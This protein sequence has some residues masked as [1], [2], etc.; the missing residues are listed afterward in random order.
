M[1][2]LKFGFLLGVLLRV[3]LVLAAQGPT[4][5]WPGTG[6]SVS[7]G[8][9]TYAVDS[10]GLA[11]N[12]SATNVTGLS[13]ISGAGEY[14]ATG[15]EVVT[16][17]AT[18]NSTLPSINFIF[19]DNDTSTVETQVIA[20][21]SGAASAQ[22]VGT[23]N[24]TYQSFGTSSPMCGYAQN[25]TAIQY[26]TAGY[27]SSGATSMYYA[28][29][30]RVYGPI[31][32]GAIDT[33]GL[34]G[35]I[36]TTNV[37]GLSSLGAN[38]YYCARAYDVLTTSVATTT[39]LPEFFISYT[40]A[41]SGVSESHQISVGVAGSP[42]AVGQ[43]GG[44]YTPG[45]VGSFCFEAKSGTAVQYSTANYASVPSG[46]VYSFHAR[47]VGPITT[48]AVDSTGLTGN[49]SSTNVPG[50]SSLGANGYYCAVGYEVVTT[51]SATSATLPFIVISYTDADTSTST[52]SYINYESSGS[53]L[54]AGSF[55]G[56]YNSNPATA[57]GF[58]FYGK[59]GTAVTYST[60]SYASTPAGMTYALHIRVIGTGQF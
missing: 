4:L 39:T 53:P 8:P 44:T 55:S 36:S 27:A 50:L 46:M 42:G 47:V 33:T 37:P 20:A 1:K 18:T 7:T 3:S 54:A 57:G 49:V 9:S 26:S 5:P 48:N 28:L 22:S 60:N 40:D 41:D 21:N 34:T 12:V 45:P 32:A 6:P 35:N 38:G 15:Y 51:A 43:T 10:T 16:T 25:A 19:T 31:S 11:A 17:A 30:I 56:T 13:S 58:C 2:A 24:G 59:S 52:S 14:C 29:H 23:V